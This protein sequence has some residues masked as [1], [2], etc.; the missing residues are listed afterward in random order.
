MS[1]ALKSPEESTPDL[2][3]FTRTIA[4]VEADNRKLMEIIRKLNNILCYADSDQCDV[5]PYHDEAGTS[6][7]PFV[8]ALRFM[9]PK[10]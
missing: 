7:C 6:L 9:H 3:P 10:P 1:I 4:D 5:C 8:E 2:T